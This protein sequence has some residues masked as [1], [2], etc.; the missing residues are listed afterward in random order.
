[1]L[2]NNL[3]IRV[4]LAMSPLGWR[5]TD[6]KWD[7]LPDRIQSRIHA[8]SDVVSQEI[9]EKSRQFHHIGWRDV[10]V[11]D[12]HISSTASLEEDKHNSSQ[13]IKHWFLKL[14]IPLDALVYLTWH[15][16]NDAV[17]Y[18]TEWG[19]FV[20]Y[21]NSFFYPFDILNIFD[22]TMQWAVLCG[23]EEVARYI[24]QN[25]SC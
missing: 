2:K 3:I 8:I 6:N 20:E 14:D 18:V 19:I 16:F 13:I 15:N 7:L 24:C 9:Q 12:Y 11:Q 1:M 5:F 10:N 25:S 4:D 22:D 21:W 17:A 23:T